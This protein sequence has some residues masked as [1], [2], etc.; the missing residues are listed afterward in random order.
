[1]HTA[2]TTVPPYLDGATTPATLEHSLLQENLVQIILP[3][4][5]ILTYFKPHILNLIFKFIHWFEFF[6]Q[7]LPEDVHKRWQKHVG[8]FQGIKKFTYH[9]CTCWLYSHAVAYFCL[10]HNF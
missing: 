4:F 2:D 7:H 6:V 8:G 5:Y 9:I 3:V 10:Q 1:M